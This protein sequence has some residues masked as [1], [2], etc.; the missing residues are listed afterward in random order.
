[1]SVC[2]RRSG[3]LH[4]YLHTIHVST[5]LN[6]FSTKRLLLLPPNNLP[7]GIMKPAPILFPLRFL[8]SWQW[9]QP[10][11]PIIWTKKHAKLCFHGAATRSFITPHGGSSKRKRSSL[12][13]GSSFRWNLLVLGRRLSKFPPPRKE[14]H[15]YDDGCPHKR[16]RYT[17][18]ATRCHANAHSVTSSRFG[19]TGAS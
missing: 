9:K 7:A 15:S 12:H 1:M 16:S 2:Q 19:W 3:H 14:G 13:F 5:I 4:I 17:T 6:F 8:I 10:E 18:H 11:P